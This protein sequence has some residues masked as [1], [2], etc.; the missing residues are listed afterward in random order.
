MQD[1]EVKYGAKKIFSKLGAKLKMTLWRRNFP[2]DL[3][4]MTLIRRSAETKPGAAPIHPTRPE[5]RVQGQFQACSLPGVSLKPQ[6]IPSPYRIW[7]AIKVRKFC[8]SRRMLE[9]LENF[10]FSCIAFIAKVK[11]TLSSFLMTHHFIF[12]LRC[13]ANTITAR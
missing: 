3:R 9:V 13:Y 6:C 12:A 4:P 5:V 10:F 7:P 1:S 11:P 2:R 8:C